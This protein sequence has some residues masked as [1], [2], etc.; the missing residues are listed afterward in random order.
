MSPARL[1]NYGPD[2]GPRDRPVGRAGTVRNSNNTG[3]FG[4]GPGRAGRPEYTPIPMILNHRGYILQPNKVSFHS[5]AGEHV[6]V[7]ECGDT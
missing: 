6:I 7:N 3:L 1:S 5:E 4:L 2:H